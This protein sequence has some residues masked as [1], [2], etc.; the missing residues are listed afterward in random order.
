MLNIFSL[1]QT[2]KTWVSFKIPKHLCK[3]DSRAAAMI[4]HA[5]LQSAYIFFDTATYDEIERD[6]KVYKSNWEQLWNI[7]KVESE[8]RVK[9]RF[10]ILRA[11]S[12]RSFGAV[13]VGD[14]FCPIK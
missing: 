9:T 7:R 2:S 10:V 4:E 1:T 13:F 6:V 8:E 11:A 5:P 12:K 3:S 14:T